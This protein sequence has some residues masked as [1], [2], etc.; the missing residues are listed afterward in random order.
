MFTLVPIG[1]VRCGRAEVTD[2]FWGGLRSTIEL[3]E[4]VSEDSL[5][6]LEEFSHAEIFYVFDRVDENNIVS[7]ARHPR[8][9]SRWPCVGIFAQRAK[10]RPNRLG[11]TIVRIVAKEG[12][13]LI[14]EG[15]DAVNGTPVVDIKPVMS[16][17]LPGELV[18]QPDWSRELMKDYWIPEAVRNER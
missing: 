2:D 6:G 5:I 1:V 7:G 14:V 11:A 15:L 12:R 18:R 13:S 8:D 4:E 3:V 9:N 17:F 10:G 16:E